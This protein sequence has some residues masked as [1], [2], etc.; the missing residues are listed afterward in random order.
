MIESPR[1]LRCLEQMTLVTIA[2]VCDA[3]PQL[4]VIGELR[5]LVPKLC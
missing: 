3:N 4:I 5:A 1:Q 2:E